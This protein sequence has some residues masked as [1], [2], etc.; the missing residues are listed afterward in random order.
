LPPE[1]GLAMMMS[2]LSCWNQGQGTNDAL[3]MRT[4]GQVMTWNVANTHYTPQAKDEFARADRADAFLVATAKAHGFNL[5]THELGKPET[6][7]RVLFPML[8]MFRESIVP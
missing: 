2:Y 1:F 6:K 8:L 3:V 7:R 4:Y 5:V